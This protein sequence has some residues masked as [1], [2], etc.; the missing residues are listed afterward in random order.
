MALDQQEL[1]KALHTMDGTAALEGYRAGCQFLLLAAA[2]VG[3]SAPSE[4][5]SEDLYTLITNCC[6]EPTATAKG[7]ADGT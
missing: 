7:S 5:E 2:Q 4:Q 3:K 1:P 6:A